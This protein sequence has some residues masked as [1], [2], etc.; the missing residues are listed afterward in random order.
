MDGRD[1]EN[2][3]VVEVEVAGHRVGGGGGFTDEGSALGV[4][5]GHD[6]VFAGA[7]TDAIGQQDQASSVRVVTGGDDRVTGSEGRV[8]GVSGGVVAQ[9]G[10]A[11]LGAGLGPGPMKYKSSFPHF[12]PKQQFLIGCYGFGNDQERRAKNRWSP[13]V[14][15]LS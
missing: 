14:W 8:A 2:H 15:A 9:Q 11:M 12:G 10:A 13:L 7:G 4:L 3:A 6:E 1:V 5:E